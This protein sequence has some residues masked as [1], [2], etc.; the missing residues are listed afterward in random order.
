MIGLEGW[1]RERE[2]AE[3]SLAWLW[4][5]FQHCV[6]LWSGLRLAQTNKYSFKDNI[7]FPGVAEHYKQ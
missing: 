7:I 3:H 2:T 6:V 5:C 1:Q 4:T